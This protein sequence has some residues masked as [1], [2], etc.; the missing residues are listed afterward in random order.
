[1][2]SRT[3]ITQA[4]TPT[5]TTDVH[6]ELTHMHPV[7]NESESRI[8][9]WNGM[10]AVACEWK[11]FIITY[12]IYTS[13]RFSPVLS[14]SPFQPLALLHSFLHIK[15]ATARVDVSEI[16]DCSWVE[17]KLKIRAKP[18]ERISW[19]VGVSGKALLEHRQNCGCTC[20][21]WMNGEKKWTWIFFTLSNWVGAVNKVYAERCTQHTHTRVTTADPEAATCNFDECVSSA[22][23]L[24]F[25]YI[26]SL[27]ESHRHKNDIQLIVWILFVSVQWSALKWWNIPQ[28][29]S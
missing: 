9:I 12:C 10:H 21:Q 13:L 29:W 28:S 2:C 15:R 14:P 20:W 26:T 1:M 23:L 5:T 27:N 19:W 22:F 7:K 6:V 25:W 11:L 3:H 17:I 16:Y 24:L 8:C 4:Q 18:F